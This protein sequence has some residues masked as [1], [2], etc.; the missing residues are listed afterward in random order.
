MD[1]A[2]IQQIPV[3]LEI[4]HHLRRQTADVD[5][6]GRG[7]VEGQIPALTGGK[8]VFDTGLGIVKIAADGAD[9]HIFALLRHHL[10][11][12]HPGDAPIGI[13]DADFYTGHIRKACQCGLA[14]VAGGGSEDHDFLFGTALFHGGGQ[15]LGQHGKR[16]IL[17]GRCGAAE[18]LQHREIADGH[19]GRQILR[20]ESAGVR[21]GNKILHI[22]NIRQQRGKDGAG[23]PLGIQRQTVPP[24]EA[25][26][27]FRH[28]KAAVRRKACQ[29][30]LG[31]VCGWRAAACRMV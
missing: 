30:G 24:V 4:V 25:G 23:H 2:R 20:L 9:G 22:G 19:G 11:P 13:E 1:A 27:E 8:D 12:L 31:A 10:R 18:Q 5:G 29:N 15:Q 14:G 28:V 3:S 21:S 7:Q 16:H 6:V 26:D 17:E